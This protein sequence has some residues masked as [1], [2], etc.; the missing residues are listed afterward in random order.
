MISYLIRR[1]LLMIPTLLGI[2]IIVF[3]VTQVVPGGPVEN[4]IHQMKMGS[5]DVGGDASI[6]I[7]EE[8]RHELNK[9]YGFDKPLHERYFRWIGNVLVGEFGESYEYKEPVI[10]VIVNCFPVSLTFGLWSFVLVYLLSV[11]LGVY[12]AVNDGHGFDAL[13][14]FLLFAA[15]SIPNYAL[16]II[17]IVFLGG[18]SFW[19]LFPIQ[20]LNSDNA[21]QLETIP[22]ILDYLHHAVLPLICYIIGQFALL[23]LLMKN[24]FLE[25]I[26]QDYVRTARAKGLSEKVV[27]LK[28][29]LRNALI[30]IATGIGQYT[31]IFLMGSILLEKIFGL[32]GIGLLNYE[33]ILARDYPVVLAI[34]MLASLAT[35]VGNFISDMLYIVIDPRIHYH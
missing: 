20:G 26:S 14:S 31:A 18:G 33:S 12:K 22:Y 13:S 4:L 16:A 7:T 3:G 28:H 11:P 35:V 27:Y 8:L 9:L 17:L 2:S 23:T 5:G 32:E 15:Y 29:V 1:I 25:Q 24:S 19:E 10:Q 30:P 21:E 34:I 6:E